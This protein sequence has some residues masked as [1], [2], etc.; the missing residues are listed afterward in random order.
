[1]AI[2]CLW[3]GLGSWWL[4]LRGVPAP[5]RGVI[6]TASAEIRSGPGDNFNVSFTAPEGRRV[7]ILGTDGEWLEIGLPK[8]GVKGWIQAASVEEI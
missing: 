7:Q 8:D 1:M 2:L 4:A 3:I 6:V 5:R